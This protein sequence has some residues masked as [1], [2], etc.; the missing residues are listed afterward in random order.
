MPLEKVDAYY[1]IYTVEEE[2]ERLLFK[3]AKSKLPGFNPIR[4]YG[5]CQIESPIGINPQCTIILMNK[6][7]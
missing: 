6:V 3:F 7:L 1:E 5:Y 4:G 2:D